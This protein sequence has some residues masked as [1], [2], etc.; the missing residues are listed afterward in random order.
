MSEP[1]TEQKEAVK[2]ED[3]AMKMEEGPESNTSVKD[4]KDA[5][6][7]NEKE[8][9]SNTSVKDTKDAVTANEKEDDQKEA[10]TEESPKYENQKEEVIERTWDL[11]G[12][13]V[14]IKNVLKF[15]PPKK[16]K[17]MA[18]QWLKGM[19]NKVKFKKVKKPPKDA[20]ICVTLEEESMV[21]IFINYINNNHITNKKGN[22]LFAQRVAAGDNMYGDDN[23]GGRNGHKRGS[24]DDRDSGP[25]KR[26]R[27]E[28]EGPRIIPDEE[29]KD[30]MI[31]LW[32]KSYQEQLKEKEKDMVRRCAQKI[33]KETKDKF[34]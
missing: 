3:Q 23:D 19:D 20:W 4:T 2:P 28:N 11:T 25:N 1:T 24:A 26:Q 21:P 30:A 10:V 29:I 16:V 22:K 7:A 8:G 32:R 5:V 14:I 6:T 9:E 18:D 17:K 31:P 33:V 34:V 15:M 13:K 12:Q 27:Q